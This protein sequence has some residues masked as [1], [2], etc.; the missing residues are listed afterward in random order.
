MHFA[1]V[2]FLGLARELQGK[3][4]DEFS[5]EA[6]NRSAVS[7]AYY[8]AFCTVRNYAEMY[9]GFQRTTTAQDHEQLR[10]RLIQQGG[11][12]LVVAR[13]LNQLRQ[14]RNQC[15]YD[16]IVPNL[17]QLTISAIERASM[18]IQQCQSP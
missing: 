2:E 14:W 10:L 4:G 16:D 7:R 6:A 5:V 11:Q 18:V 12:W 9:L 1:W 8:A 13:R 15:D 17:D 3:S